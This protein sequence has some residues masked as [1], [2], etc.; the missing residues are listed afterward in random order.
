MLWGS[1]P[2]LEDRGRFATMTLN[3]ESALIMAQLLQEQ[4]AGRHH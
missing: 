4:C 1:N 3:T 2:T